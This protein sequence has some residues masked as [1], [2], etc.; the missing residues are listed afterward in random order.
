MKANVFFGTFLGAVL[1][2]SVSYAACTPE[3]A[4][5]KALEISEKMQALATSNPEKMQ[6]VSQK[7]SAAASNLSSQDGSLDKTCEAYDEILA[8][9]NS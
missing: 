4:Q 6:A 7:L 8:E 1:I 3:E 5:A 9:I 2:S